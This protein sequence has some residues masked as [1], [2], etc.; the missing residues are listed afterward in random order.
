MRS[1]VSDDMINVMLRQMGAVSIKTTPAY[2]SIAKFEVGDLRLTYMYE[3]KDENIYLQRVDPYPMMIGKIYNDQ[4]VVEIIA[5]DL[6]RFKNAYNSSNFSRF[7]KIANDMS[8]IKITING[9]SFTAELYDNDAAKEFASMLPM[10]VDASDLHSNEK[11]YYLS[12]TLPTDASR[13]DMIH[14][15]DLMLYSNNCI[16]LFYK[17]FSTSYSYTP[18]GRITD[19][20]GLENAVGKSSVRITFEAAE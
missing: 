6:Q 11:Y 9:E 1:E 19:T 5:A 12:E 7:I 4:Q 2:I 18:L 17:D 14:A 8:T 13:P 20:K 3:V 15:G 16:V 10:T